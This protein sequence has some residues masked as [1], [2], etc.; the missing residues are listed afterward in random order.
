[1]S[2]FLHVIGF[3]ALLSVAGLAQ[4]PER[5]GSLA[6]LAKTS[7]RAEHDTLV[8]RGPQEAFYITWVLGNAS[9]DLVVVP[10]SDKLLAVS[11]A[12]AGGQVVL[13]R[14]Q[15]GI[16]DVAVRPGGSIA[17][18]KN[19]LV[20]QCSTK[21]S[22]LIFMRFCDEPIVQTLCAWRLCSYSRRLS[23]RFCPYT[24]WGSAMD[25]SNIRWGCRSYRD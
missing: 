15:L 11:L 14:R 24:D 12:A 10:P 21:M 7:S 19:L 8:F 4:R 23:S 6:S 9:G 22:P 18:S 17:D 25:G 13:G 5:F 2:R 16:D 3:I 20:S 1:M